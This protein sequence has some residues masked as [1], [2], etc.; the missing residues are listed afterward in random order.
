MRRRVGRLLRECLDRA[1]VRAGLDH[2]EGC[3]LQAQYGDGCDR[4][5][6]ARGSMLIDHLHRVH[7][8]HVAGAEHGHEIRL[9]VVDQVQRLVDR[10]RR[11]GLPVRPSR[12]WAGTGVT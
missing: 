2:P 7:P 4:D 9:L 5:A 8:E 11:A 1:P 12:C 10:V 3:C 6:G